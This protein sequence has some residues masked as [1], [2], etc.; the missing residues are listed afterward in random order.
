MRLVL[1]TLKGVLFWSYERGTWQYDLMC[2]LILAFVFLGPN[3][4]FHRRHTA[5]ASN[6]TFV[7]REEVKPEDDSDLERKIAEHLSKKC[8]CEVKVSHIEP[9]MDRS[10]N[11]KG[12]QVTL[13]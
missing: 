11:L 13:K 10:G 8:G 3:S 7:A 2:V 12:Y 1:A 9:L 5:P 6:L 4:V